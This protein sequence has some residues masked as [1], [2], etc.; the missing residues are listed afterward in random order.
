[1]G[2]KAREGTYKQCSPRLC[3]IRPK[4]GGS[5]TMATMAPQRAVPSCGTVGGVSPGA[6]AEAIS[7]FLRAFRKLFGGWSSSS[8]AAVRS[9]SV[10]A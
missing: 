1:M 7:S 3:C 4:F 6:S 10:V 9:S 5:G 8:G 2:M